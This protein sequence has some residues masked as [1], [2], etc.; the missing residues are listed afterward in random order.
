MSLH[1]INQ[2]LT[3]VQLEVLKVFSYNLDEKEL[4]EFKDLVA[5][6]F[7]NRSIELADKAWEEKGWTDKDVD[8]MLGTKMRTNKKD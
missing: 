4:K 8:E 3:N 5:G 1:E 6:Y 2:P 7:A